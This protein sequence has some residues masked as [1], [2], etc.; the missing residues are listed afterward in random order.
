MYD[1]AS[2]LSVTSNSVAASNAIVSGGGAI[3]V[4]KVT[5]NGDGSNALILDVYNQLTVTGT[6]EISIRAN[7]EFSGQFSRYI[8]A[9]FD[10]P[11]EYNVG[12]TLAFTGNGPIGKVYY[13]R[14]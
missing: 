12:L 11:V 14:R 8:E 6:P 3:R 2:V 1:N 13:T 5:L 9:D 10:P 4:H 7:Q